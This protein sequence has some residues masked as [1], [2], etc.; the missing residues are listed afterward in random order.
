MAA[1]KDIIDAHNQR[2]IDA[3]R[4]SYCIKL[5]LNLYDARFTQS[6]IR[7]IRNAMNTEI[8]VEKQSSVN[9]SHV[10]NFIC[11]ASLRLIFFVCSV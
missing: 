8:K 11:V 5:A 7:T 2:E 9:Y 3:E 6:Q 1:N 10:H 4:K